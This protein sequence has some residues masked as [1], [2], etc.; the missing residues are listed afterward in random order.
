MKNN[1]LIL[2]DWDDTLFPTSWITNNSIN[3]F[4]NKNIKKKIMLLSKLDYILY[5]FLKK[6]LNYGTVIIVTNA[7]KLWVY[8]SI[9]YLPYSSKIINNKIKLIS[10]RDKYGHLNNP[11]LWKQYVFE[12]EVKIFFYNN[13]NIHNIISIGDAEYE[14]KALINFYEWKKIIPKKRILKKIKFI[15]SPSYSS[16]IYQIKILTKCINK[17]YNKKKH[18]DLL[19]KIKN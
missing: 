19:F 17:I 9:K 16:V 13:K 3:I 2:I 12:D 7:S 15:S 1:T 11:Y 6:S 8:N 10:A 14:H 5:R 4:N 18:V